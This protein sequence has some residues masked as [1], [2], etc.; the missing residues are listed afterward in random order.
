MSSRRNE[1]RSALVTILQGINGIA[2]YETAPLK[3]YTVNLPITQLQL[4]C[5]IVGDDDEEHEDRTLRINDIKMNV[6]VMFLTA[7][8]DPS[9]RVQ[10]VDKQIADCER[11]IESNPSLGLASYGVR[12]RVARII[13][14]SGVDDMDID[15]ASVTVEVNYRQTRGAP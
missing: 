14:Q 3:V 1:I 12:A 10:Y 9:L 5:A 2:P 15:A 11:A 13:R 6:D 7:L 8:R 4:P